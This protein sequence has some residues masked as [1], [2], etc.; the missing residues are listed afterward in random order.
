MEKSEKELKEEIKRL[1]TEYSLID[2]AIGYFSK[3]G[4]PA[5]FVGVKKSLK[6]KKR[7][8]RDG[9]REI[10]KQLRFPSRR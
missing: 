9:I 3:Y 8:L 10:R 7:K 1:E 5:K 2:Q 6:E 4:E